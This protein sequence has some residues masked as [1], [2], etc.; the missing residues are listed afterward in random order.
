MIIKFQ[1]SNYSLVF[2]ILVCRVVDQHFGGKH[3][4]KFNETYSNFLV[5]CYGIRNKKCLLFKI[6][7]NNINDNNNKKN[8][9]FKIVKLF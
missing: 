6:V 9:F 1:K 8:D 4:V 7:H 3:Y 5:S 2:K